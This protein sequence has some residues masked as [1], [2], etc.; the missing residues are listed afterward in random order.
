MH[1]NYWQQN[2]GAS[3]HDDYQGQ[4]SGFAALA[5]VCTTQMLHKPF[6]ISCNVLSLANQGLLH[7]NTQTFAS[8]HRIREMPR[9]TRDQQNQAIS[10]LQI[11]AS[12]R[13]IAFQFNCV[14]STILHLQHQHQQMGS[15]QDQLRPGCEC[16]TS[17]EQDQ[18]LVDE[19][20]ANCCHPA[21]QSAQDQV[22]SS[23]TVRCAGWQLL[24]SEHTT[25]L[26]V[27]Y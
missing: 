9:L 15:V 17:A 2:R 22:I 21:T 4:L 6:A 19:H 18:A 23:S 27:P 10:Q 7:M 8:T 14:H 13:R 20:L 26:L 12:L 1:I 16:A 25:P 24:D 11:G 3:F 5:H